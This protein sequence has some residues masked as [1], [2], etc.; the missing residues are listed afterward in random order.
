MDFNINKPILVH[1]NVKVSYVIWSIIDG[2]NFKIFFLYFLISD[3]DEC[4]QND[5]LCNIK[6]NSEMACSNILGTYVCESKSCPPGYN[7]KVMDHGKRFDSILFTLCV[8][9]LLMY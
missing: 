8:Q 1:G 2:G 6:A 9:F 7:R 5:Q 4:A 3:I